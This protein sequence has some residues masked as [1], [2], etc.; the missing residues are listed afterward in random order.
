MNKITW[1]VFALFSV[2]IF[3]FFVYVSNQSRIDVSKTDIS[4]AQIGTKSNGNI[5]DQVYGNKNAK[6]TI[7]EYADYQCPGCGEVAPIIKAAVDAY[8][9]QVQLIFRNFPLTSIHANA[10]LAA[11]SAEAAGLQGK[12]WEMHDAIYSG[13]QDWST[14]TGDDRVD[15]FVNLAKSLKL[16]TNKFKTD[17]SSDVVS[18]KIAYDVAMVNKAKVTQTPT[19][20]INGKLI[21]GETLNSVDNLKKAIKE[22]LK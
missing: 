6:V 5:A 16:D 18:K 2:G 12:F 22:A 21:E 11:S 14:L 10:K 13:Q 15:Y 17:V 7:I 9:D 19:L 20:F 1:S 8:I 3:M 4:V